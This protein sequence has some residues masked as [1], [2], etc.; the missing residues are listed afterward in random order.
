MASSGSLFCSASVFD[1]SKL[2]MPSPGE[3]GREDVPLSPP[4]PDL[5]VDTPNL[6]S[7]FVAELPFLKFW[8]DPIT[9]DW[10]ADFGIFFGIGILFFC[11]LRF[12][13]EEVEERKILD[14]A[15]REVLTHGL[16]CK[17]L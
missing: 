12:V 15:P 11:N 1:D 14:E 4:D 6:S 3:S 5:E 17:G 7:R 9:S 10:V 2:V 8:G 16:I 13:D